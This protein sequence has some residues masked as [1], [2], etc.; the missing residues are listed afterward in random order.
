MKSAFLALILVLTACG[1][2]AGPVAQS[3]IQPTAPAAN[4]LLATPSPSPTPSATA[5]PNHAT[6]PSPSPTPSAAASPIHVT[7]PAAGLLF[8][9]TEGGYPPPINVSQPGTVAIVGLNGYAKAKVKFQPRTV[10]GIPDSATPQQGVAQVVGSGVY[11]IDGA[12]TVRLLRVGSQPQVVARFPLQPAQEDAWFAVSPD[13]SR[14]LAGI[15]TFPAVGPTPSGSPWPELVGP[16]KFDLETAPAGGQSKTLVH[17]EVPQCCN[18]PTPIFPVGW[19]TAGPVAMVPQYVVTQND[20]PGGP[21]Y[22]IDDAGKKTT[23][24]GGSDCDSASITSSGLIPC[25][26]GTGVVSVRH[27]T[28]KLLWATDASGFDALSLYLSPDGGAISDGNEVETRAGGLVPVPSGFQI[29]GW[30]DG[31]TVIGRPGGDGDLS[32]ISLG[33]PTKVH[34]LGFKGDFVATV[35]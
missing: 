19:I 13:G 12:G 30:L 5:S 28:G 29:E 14:I 15:L 35:A 21:L 8:A 9:V 32:W 1:S 7:P 10:P 6:P 22:Q 26:S 34:D 18:L 4:A 2:A 20:W 17:L 24:L 33:D 16:S 31:N 25:I 23:Q 11:Y 27:T 3:S